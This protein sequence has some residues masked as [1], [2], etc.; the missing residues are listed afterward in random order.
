MGLA[1][2]AADTQ[3]LEERTEGWIA[4]LQLAAISVNGRANPSA[5]IAAFSGTG[6]YIVDYLVE[7]VLQRLSPELRQ[8]LFST[9]ILRQFNADL[10]D[11]MTGHPGAARALLDQLEKQNLFL[12]PLDDHRQWYRHHHLFADVLLAHMPAE[13]QHELPRLHR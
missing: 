12:V 5:F 2:S 1:L 13:R 9:C 3:I 4:A 8:F 10:C 7:E 6:R 11:A